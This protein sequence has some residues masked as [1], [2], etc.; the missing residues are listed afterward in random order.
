MNRVLSTAIAIA[1]LASS[2]FAGCKPTAETPPPEASLTL[3]P[4]WQAGEITMM[5]ITRTDTG[6]LVAV[7]EMEVQAEEGGWVLISRTN[8]AT[9]TETSSVHVGADTLTPTLAEYERLDSQGKTTAKAVYSADKVTATANVYGTEQKPAEIKLPAPPYFDNDQLIMTLRAM[10]LAN[11]WTG[12][13]SDVVWK[14]AQKAM[15]ALKATGPVSVTVPAGTFNCWVVELVGFG[16]RAWI[17]VDP[18]RALIQFENDQ[19]KT[20]SVI[21]QYTAGQ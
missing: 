6:E 2:L 4:P 1:L 13:V 16:Q 9:V 7:W 11:G 5:D 20:R 3:T 14:T 19:A 8:T 12:S 21:K 10:P 17:S 18:P 15:V